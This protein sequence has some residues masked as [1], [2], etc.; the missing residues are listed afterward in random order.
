M[1]HYTE[2]GL[3]NIWL[4]NGYHRHA[5]PYGAGIAIDNVE[6]LHRLIASQLI[7]DKPH[8]SGAEFRFLRK[9]LDLSQ[10]A[11]AAIMGKDVQSVARWEKKGRVPKMADRMLRFVFQGYTLGNA[12][13]KN[14]VERLNELDQQTYEKMQFKKSGKDWKPIAA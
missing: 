8:L 13:I 11:L 12:K 4:S 5:T 10:A 7:H 14:L 6:G 1:Y 9:E 3:N 2:S